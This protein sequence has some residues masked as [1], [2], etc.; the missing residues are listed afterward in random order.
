[1][2]LFPN[3]SSLKSKAARIF[4]MSM[5]FISTLVLLKVVIIPCASDFVLFTLPHLLVSARTLFSP[6]F[7]CIIVIFIIMTIAVSSTFHRKTVPFSDP[8]HTTT[9]FSA[10]YDFITETDY[11]VPD[12]SEVHPSEPERQSNNPEEE[13]KPELEDSALSCDDPPPEKCANDY[14]SPDA[15]DTLDATWRAIMEGQGK[16]EK[17]QLKKS[18]TCGARIEKA[19]PFRDDEDDEDDPVA[20]AR[21]ELKKSETFND[22]ASLRRDKSMTPEELNLRAEA[23][24]QNF[25]NQMRL[26]RLESDQRFMEMVNR[27][28]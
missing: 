9:I 1:M 8:K 11:A 25:I 13:E 7:V 4:L 18:D 22:T 12:L 19:E 24:I 28:A 23:F 5:G 15:D 2:D 6:G 16:T 17:P 20:W 21:K 26:Q 10:A 27:S 3:P 14:V